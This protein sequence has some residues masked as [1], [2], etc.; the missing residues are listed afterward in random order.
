MVKL[1]S[2]SSGQPGRRISL[3]RW[4][5][6]EAAVDLTDDLHADRLDWWRLIPFVLLHLGCLG[7]IWVGVSQTSVLVA[8]ILYALR[9]FAVTGFYHR[10][11]SHAAFRTSRKVQFIFAVIGASSVQ[12]GA[13][14]W[15]SQHRHHHLHSDQPADAHSP[16]QHGFFWSHMGW[17]MARGNFATRRELL[18]RLGQFPELRFLDRFDSLVPVLLALA[19]YLLGETLAWVAPHLATS[20][21]QLLVWGF[22]ISTVALYHATFSINSLAHC[23]GRRRYRTHDNSRNSAILAILTFGEG[24]HNNHHHY[25]GAVRQGVAWWEFDLTYYGLRLLAAFGLIWDLK[26]MPESLRSASLERSQRS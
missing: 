18:G 14:W 13:L 2:D 20:G 12:R 11:F 15:A 23:F 16:G 3:L 4:I 9:M 25:P 26:E 22:F 5:D 1:E 19:L 6:N 17:F 10:Y 24:W 21:P 7:V 8:A